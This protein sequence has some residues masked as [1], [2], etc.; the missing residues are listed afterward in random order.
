MTLDDLRELHKSY[1]A[2]LGR[3]TGF[4]HEHD[5]STRPEGIYHLIQRLEQAGTTHVGEFGSGFST[6]GLR[7]WRKQTGRKI[8][9]STYEHDDK[10]IG[11]IRQLLA[12]NELP[13]DA[14]ATIDAYK[15]KTLM[16]SSPPFDAVFIDHGPTMAARWNDVPWIIS[17]VKPGGLVIFDDWWPEHVRA[18]RSTKRILRILTRMG[19]TWEVIEESRPAGFDK[20][21]AVVRKP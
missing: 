12:N 9:F 4:L 8:A 11:F 15:D 19:L 5:A 18:F 3:Y 17:L 1:M 16:L 21:I 20:A 6:F 13:N 10:W 7:T 14:V 2:Q